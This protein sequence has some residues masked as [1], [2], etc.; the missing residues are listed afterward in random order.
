MH[1][2]ARRPSA[3]DVVAM[4]VIVATSCGGPSDGDDTL[5]V[6]AAASLAE[7]FGEI[8]EA[9]EA[10]D[11]GVEVVLNAGPS[12]GLREQILAG[13]PADVYASANIDEMD[14]LVEAGVAQAPVVIATNDMV[15]AVPAGNPGDVRGV[16]DL[17]DSELLVGLCA[18]PVP[19]GQAGRAVLDR[20]G[21]TPS[22][23]TDATDARALVTLL[24][25]G[26]L[27]AGIVYRTDVLAA[28]DALDGIDLPAAANV[29]ARYA[30]AEVDGPHEG[31]AAARFVAFVAS[32]RGQ[33][34]LRSYGFAPPP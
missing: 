28:G 29:A 33:D 2:R 19:C 6:F 18:Q 22:V 14:R 3:I 9:F 23:D 5:R 21:V 30:A 34:I 24:V 20:A 25:A 11:A 12:S 10:T 7:A 15:L 31:D 1:G 26:E 17:A 27:D 8:A 16:E 13:A 4:A 32:R